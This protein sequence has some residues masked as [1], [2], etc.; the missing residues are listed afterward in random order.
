MTGLCRVVDYGA[1]VLIDPQLVPKEDAEAWADRLN[2]QYPRVE[3][4]A[5]DAWNLGLLLYGCGIDSDEAHDLAKDVFLGKIAD[6][7]IVTDG[8]G[9]ITN[10]AKS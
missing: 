10:W 8:S 3:F 6:R 1:S 4:V 9:R 7:F 2:K 5:L